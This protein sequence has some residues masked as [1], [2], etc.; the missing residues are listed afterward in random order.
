MIRYFPNT[1]FAKCFIIFGLLVGALLPV[2]A[3]PTFE[4][5]RQWVELHFSGK[6]FDENQ[7]YLFQVHHRFRDTYSTL[8]EF[9]GRIGFLYDISERVSVGLGYDINPLDVSTIKKYAT[10]QNLWQQ[11]V[12]KVVKN[13]PYLVSARTR[14]EERITGNQLG[15]GLRFRQYIGLVLPKIIY[16]KIAPVI[17]N[18]VFLNLNYPSWN[19]QRRFNQNRVFVGLQCKLMDNVRLRAGYMNLFEKKA[20]VNEIDHIALVIIT[21]NQD[22]L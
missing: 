12:L 17:N 19:S 10:I 1:F 3:S 13:R 4:T 15:T 7:H 11:I 2:H 21:I 14:L 9:L 16:H 8:D 18:E 20:T 5:S 22:I 6:L